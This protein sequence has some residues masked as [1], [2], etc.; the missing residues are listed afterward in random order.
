MSSTACS[1][2]QAFW[3]T[4]AMDLSRK[5]RRAPRTGMLAGVIGGVGEY[6]SV[7]VTLLRVIFIFVTLL[8]GVFPGVIGYFLAALIMPTDAPVIHEHTEDTRHTQ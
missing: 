1:G 7:D 2:P 3:Y 4:R 8:T 5:L 6:F